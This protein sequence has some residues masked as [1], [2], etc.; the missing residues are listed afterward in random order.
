[1]EPRKISHNKARGVYYSSQFGAKQRKNNMHAFL[2]KSTQKVR[3]IVVAR[4][5]TKTIPSNK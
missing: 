1:M 4:Y 2:R 3:K 5:V